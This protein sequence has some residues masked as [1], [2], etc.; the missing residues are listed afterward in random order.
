MERFLVECITIVVGAGLIIFR[1]QFVD[2]A[3]SFQREYL[4]IDR[5]TESLSRA[6]KTIPFFGALLILLG[7]WNLINLLLG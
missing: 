5:N 7:L 1:K 6:G 4:K 3:I 2:I